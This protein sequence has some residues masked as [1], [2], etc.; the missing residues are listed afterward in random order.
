[1]SYDVGVQLPPPAPLFYWEAVQLGRALNLSKP[2]T[3]LIKEIRRII[4]LFFRLS[5]IYWFISGANKN[6]D[7]K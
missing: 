3:K 5:I 6:A 2:P 7:L 1:M 4:D